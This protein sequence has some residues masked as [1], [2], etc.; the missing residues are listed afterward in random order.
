M[1]NLSFSVSGDAFGTDD[2]E[3]VSA[4]RD[5]PQW[6]R[7]LRRRA[8]EEFGRLS[9]QR[10]NPEEFRFRLRNFE[11]ERFA[12][13]KQ[14]SGEGRRELTRLSSQLSVLPQEHT[15]GKLVLVDGEV[16]WCTL[17]ERTAQA[18]VVFGGLNE[19]VRRNEKLIQRFLGRA[20]SPTADRF[21]AWHTA[22][23]TG[24]TVLYVPA[25]VR[26]E[27]PLHSLLVLDH[28]NAAD[29]SHTL[30]VLEEGASATLLEETVSTTK[31]RAGLHV[32]AVELLLAP[33]AE[34]HFVQLQNW[35]THTWHFAR[36][37]GLVEQD[38]QL[39]W[40]VAALGAQTAHVH[41]HVKLCG[42]N[43]Q[44][45]INGLSFTTENQ[46]HSFFTQQTHSAPQTRSNLLYKEVL[47]D[48]S[49][50]VWR[51]M[52]EVPPDAQRTDG[53]QRNDALLLNEGCRVEAIP[54]L[55]IQADDVRCTHGTTL[56]RLN[57]EE[58][59]YCTSRGLS[60][61]EAVRLIVGGFLRVVSD[62]I[63]S[64]T[65]Q[66]A[67]NRALDQALQSV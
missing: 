7:E 45:D 8:F 6:W 38:A 1:A 61:A 27:H 13:L 29:F 31:E 37:S 63:A 22:F 51:G 42:P 4:R 14:E 44:A 54:G 21:T 48:R 36:Q 50:V 55:E 34:L 25:G 40:T 16:G 58:L 66:T 60:R 23:C 56:G 35:N 18:G 39:K 26:V 57:D 2:F 11:P 65:V 62:R 5:E 12:V 33:G 19:L 41:Q 53:Y 59:F 32:G 43:A 3:R 47:K 15:D 24:G 64:E 9:E 17:A 30:V 52:I 67:I 49:Q 46:C 20:V 28:E 10:L